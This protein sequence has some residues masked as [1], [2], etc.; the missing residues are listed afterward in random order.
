MADTEVL[1]MLFD[2]SNGL[3]GLGVGIEQDQLSSLTSTLPLPETTGP[4][5]ALNENEID[6]TSFF[7]GG[8]VSIFF[9]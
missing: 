9:F 6:W 5:M 2:T 8:L 4:A 1:D 7:N 3:L